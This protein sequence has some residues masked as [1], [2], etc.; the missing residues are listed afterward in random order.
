MPVSTDTYR[1]D[2]TAD[3]YIAALNAVADIIDNI[4]PAKFGDR[5]AVVVGL[6]QKA[7]LFIKK[8]APYIKDVAPAVAPHVQKAV[9]AVADK[10]PE[11]VGAQ[12]AKVADAAK[13]AANK[14]VDTANKAGGAMHDAAEKRA[15]EKARKLA[16]KTLLS[17]AG[18]HIEAQTFLKTWDDQRDLASKLDGP[19]AAGIDLYAFSGCYITVTCDG[20]VKKDD[21]SKYR[22]VYVGKAANMGEAIHADF[23]GGGNPDVYA[24]V[25]YKQHVYVLLYPCEVEKLDEMHASLVAA[26]DADRS[27]NRW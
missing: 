21:F 5:G 1:Q 25:K 13:S 12:A 23:T 11:A 6:A 26:L 18:R 27:Y 4:D 24:D 8:A 22:E 2:R 3:S 16:R 10:A 14:V 15:Q 9:H 17:G 20:A 7:V 19:A